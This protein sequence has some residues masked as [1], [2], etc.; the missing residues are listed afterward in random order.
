MTDRNAAHGRMV[1]ADRRMVQV[2]LTLVRVPPNFYPLALTNT[3]FLGTFFTFF[4]SF[5]PSQ[6]HE[7][8]I[9][10]TSW[11]FHMRLVIN[12]HVAL[13]RFIMFHCEGIL[14]FFASVLSKN[15]VLFL[16]II[17]FISYKKVGR[18]LFALRNPYSEILTFPYSALI[19]GVSI[20]I[21]HS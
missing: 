21:L 6:N 19:T 11:D 3:R 1:V 10:K 16:K 17:R 8:S 4:C 13:W 14:M 15:L 20:L 2:T 18:H 9:I 5:F 7:D 12:L